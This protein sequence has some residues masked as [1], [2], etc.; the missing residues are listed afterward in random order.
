LDDL[1]FDQ[2]E[3][4]N[5]PVSSAVTVKTMTINYSIQYPLKT[6]IASDAEKEQFY[7]NEAHCIAPAPATVAALGFEIWG[8]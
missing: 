6:L 7:A 1:Q 2:P 8:L 4:K 3:N 5:R